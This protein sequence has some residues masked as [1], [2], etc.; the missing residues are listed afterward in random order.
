VTLEAMT[1][2]LPVVAS[3]VGGIPDKVVE[4]GTG[5]LVPPGDASALAERIA[6]MAGHLGEAREMGVRGARLAEEQFSWRQI[7][8]RTEELFIELIDEKSACRAAVGA[9]REPPVQHRP[10]LGSED[11]PFA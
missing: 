4:G 11:R 6:W 3:A 10:P 8:A 5:F 2:R 1:H 7:A 9:V